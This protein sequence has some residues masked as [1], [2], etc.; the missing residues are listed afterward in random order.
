MKTLKIYC[1]VTIEDK[2]N[3]QRHPLTEVQNAANLVRNFKDNSEEIVYSNSP[4][5]VSMIKYLS[6]EYEIETEFFLDG[7][8]TGDGIEIIFEDFNKAYDLMDKLIDN[9]EYE[10]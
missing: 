2:C 1:G 7:I 3:I 9:D 5:F 4:D 8:S 6:P 10:K